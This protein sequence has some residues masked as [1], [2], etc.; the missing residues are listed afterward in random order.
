MEADWEIEVGPGAPVI[1]GEWE[2]F[3]DLRKSPNRISEIA[4][5]KQSP[6]LADALLGLNS[7]ASQWWTSKC[8]LWSPAEWDPDEMNATPKDARAA[9]ACY[10]DLLPREA[11][12]FPSIESAEAPARSILARLKPFPAACCRIDLIVRSA[13]LTHKTGYGITAYITACGA[14]SDAA[15]SSLGAALNAFVNASH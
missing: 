5:A 11:Q 12:V 6:A 13:A 9:S 1:D 15:A 2:G 4:E 10:I 14:T 8:D 7:D 3:I